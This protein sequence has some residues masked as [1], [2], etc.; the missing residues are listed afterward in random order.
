MR[1]IGCGVVR[2]DPWRQ[3]VFIARKE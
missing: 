2:S 1:S 3:D